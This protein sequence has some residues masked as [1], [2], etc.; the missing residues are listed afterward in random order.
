MSE[1][2]EYGMV[3]F[4]S[5]FMTHFSQ[6]GL[7]FDIVTSKSFNGLIL[8]SVALLGLIAFGLTSLG[9]FG[10]LWWVSFWS[11]KRSYLVSF[12]SFWVS[13]KERPI[14]DQERPKQDRRDHNKTKGDSFETKRRPNCHYLVRGWSLGGVACLWWWCEV[15]RSDEVRWWMV[16]AMVRSWWWA[17]DPKMFIK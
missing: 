13:H 15:R 9:L 10:S 6:S 5:H 2:H 3:L 12:R 11:S 1:I 16:H 4:W 14:Q 8:V 17:A 7:I